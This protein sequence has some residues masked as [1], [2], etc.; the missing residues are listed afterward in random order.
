MNEAVEAATAVP[1]GGVGRSAGLYKPL[2]LVTGF[3]FLASTI[4][5]ALTLPGDTAG[6]WGMFTATYLFLLGL[7]QFG[8]AYTAIMRLTGGWW[9]RPFFRLAEVTTLAYLP[10]AFI[11]LLVVY[12]FGREQLFFWL[13][14]A[15]GE[16]LSV[17]LGEGK[18]LT[19]NLVALLG[20]YLVAYLYIRKGLR[21]D[22]ASGANDGASRRFV[23]ALFG[24]HR[25][26]DAAALTGELYRWST[27][28]LFVGALAA[29]FVSWD[30]AMMLWP[31][32]HS[33]IF[34]MYYMVGAIYGGIA[35]LLLL[36]ALL[37]QCIDMDP[38][39]GVR[40]IKNTG[41]LLTG[42][43]CLWLYFFWAQ[44]FVTWF[45][46]LPHEMRPLNAQMHGHYAPVFWVSIA[47]LF[48][49]PLALLIFAWV[50]RRL[51]SAA[52]V[53]GLVVT[54][55]F[56][57]RYLMVVPPQWDH[58]LPFSTPGG[59]AGSLALLSGFLFVLLL[60]FHAFP[61]LSRWEIEA[62]P[63]AQRAHWHSDH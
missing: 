21:P 5:A 33:T 61:M 3:V 58:H 37:R 62:I 22:L 47:C 27:F 4:V 29:T 18:L 14:P 16:H 34:T 48:C 56:L 53:A 26:A 40:Q 43:M 20:F 8:I 28:I 32:Y 35:L 15:P 44:F 59:A 49:L 50:K 60:L 10:F 23:A 36:A 52:F 30:L 38:V 57:N 51:W 63:A 31:H 25:E 12:Y 46:N 11:G 7:T 1:V 45:G 42:F 6:G 13:D 41:I 9:A 54:G 17:W 55:V 24:G 2:T 39:F 19:R